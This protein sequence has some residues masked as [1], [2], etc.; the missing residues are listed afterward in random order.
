MDVSFLTLIDI[1]VRMLLFEKFKNTLRIDSYKNDTA[2]WP[3]GIALRKMS[4][5]VGEVSLEFINLW[6]RSC[7]PAW[8]RQRTS[9]ARTGMLSEYVSQEKA[10]LV[11]GKAMPV[12]L[13]YDFWVWSKDLEKIYKIIEDY[14]FWQHR[15]PNLDLEID[16]T[17]PISL[18]LHFGEV[19]DESPIEQM[20]D[21]GL[22]FVYRFPLIVDG[23]IIEGLSLKTIHTLVLKM[24]QDID[25]DGP[26]EKDIIL[27]SEEVD[28]TED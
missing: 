9:V 13:K 7:A 26:K 3:K 10:S 18:Q 17:Y 8:N 2:R 6:R 1:G 19:I 5:R 21:K 11:Q 24:Y 22:Y 20:Y 16:E 14:I 23:W 25:P 4:E 15:S 27:F 12:D 28:L